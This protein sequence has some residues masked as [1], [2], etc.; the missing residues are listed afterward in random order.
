MDIL[1]S[2]SHSLVFFL[3]LFR[4]QVGKRGAICQVPWWWRENPAPESLPLGSGQQ[5]HKTKWAP[6]PESCHTGP[7]LPL[8]PLPAITLLGSPDL[9]L[10]KRQGIQRM[11]SLWESKCWGANPLV[12]V[13]TYF[14]HFSV[15]FVFPLKD[16]LPRN[17]TTE[18]CFP[19]KPYFSCLPHY[20]TCNFFFTPWRYTRI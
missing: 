7:V 18:S 19:L 11:W 5:G 14:K 13:K 1:S 17:S 10:V 3:H 9:Q 15:I 16:N 4:T 6:E 20:V 8:H 12:A 2:T